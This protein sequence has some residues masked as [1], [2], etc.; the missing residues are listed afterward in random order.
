MRETTENQA[1]LSF[2]AHLE[3]IGAGR[4][5]GRGHAQELP[6]GR[7]RRASVARRASGFDAA[8]AGLNDHEGELVPAGARPDGVLWRLH[9]GTAR[10]GAA[11]A[12]DASGALA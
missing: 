6:G 3:V 5:A 11:V 7:C 1:I 9:P 8:L 12:Q 4:E 10:I 2:R